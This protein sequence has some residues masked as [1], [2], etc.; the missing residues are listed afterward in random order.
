VPGVFLL[1]AWS[2]STGFIVVEDMSGTEALGAS[3][4]ATAA[5]RWPLFFA[6]L[7]YGAVI[8]GA[9]VAIIFT[10]MELVAEGSLTQSLIINVA[11]SLL[12][13]AG[14]VLGAAVY[15]QARPAAGSLDAIFA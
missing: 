13:I 8:I 1:A 14:W 10:E 11:T 4:Q 9:M 12:T 7:L 3:W 5:A 15:R 6:F 2:A